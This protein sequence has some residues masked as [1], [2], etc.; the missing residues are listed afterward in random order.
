MVKK[1]LLTLIV[2]TLVNLGLCLTY[3]S[4]KLVYAG[5]SASCSIDCPNGGSASCSV[6]CPQFGCTCECSTTGGST[7]SCLAYC[8][9]GSDDAHDCGAGSGGGIFPILVPPPF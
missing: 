6:S 8:S 2:L 4:F 7:P 3:P 9:D 1:L 5:S